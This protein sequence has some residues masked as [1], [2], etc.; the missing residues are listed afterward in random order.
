MDCYP[1]TSQFR[2]PHYHFTPSGPGVFAQS[3]LDPADPSHNVSSPIIEASIGP[4]DLDDYSDESDHDDVDHFSALLDNAPRGVKS[5]ETL[6]QCDIPLDQDGPPDFEPLRVQKRARNIHLPTDFW[7]RTF[8]AN[9]HQPICSCL[10]CSQ[11]KEHS[12][13]GEE[14]PQEASNENSSGSRRSE[15]S[16]PLRFFF[17]MWPFELFEDLATNT[18]LYEQYQ[19]GKSSNPRRPWKETNAAELCIWIGLIIYMGVFTRGGPTSELWSRSGEFPYHCISRFRSLNRFEQIKRY[20]HIGKQDT[21]KLPCEE[22]FEKLNPLASKLRENWKK[23]ITP[24]AF[25]SLDEMMIRF[26]GRSSHTYLIRNK[27]IPVGYKLH[28]LCDAG[29]CWTWIWDSPVL[30]APPPP[31]KADGMELSDTANQVLAL[32]LQLPWQ[33]QWQQFQIFMDN[34]YTSIR[35]LHILRKYGIAAT[36]TARS[37]QKDYP[38]AHKAINREKDKWWWGTQSSIVVK[39]IGESGS[40]RAARKILRPENES[41]LSTMWMDRT[42][43]RM[44]TTAYTGQ[45][46]ELVPRRK[47]RAKDAYTKWIIGRY[48][49]QTQQA[50]LLLPLLSV[51][52]NFHMGGVDI[53][54]Q[55]RSYLSTQLKTWRSWFPLFFWLIDQSIINAFILCNMEFKGSKDPNLTNHRQFRIRLAW[56]LVILGASMLE[57]EELLNFSRYGLGKYGNQNATLKKSSRI[58]GYVTDNYEFPQLRLLSSLPHRRSTMPAGKRRCCKFCLVLQRK[59]LTLKKPTFTPVE[60]VV[61]HNTPLCT[62]HFEAFHCP[63][64]SDLGREDGGSGS[65]GGL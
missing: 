51:H 53:A 7:S 3:G 16:T 24:S 55:Y 56:N 61:C 41:V 31:E 6:R 39:E 26:T 17:L 12:T 65:G 10:A 35:A 13:S 14:I 60:C 58:G 28:A 57:H 4:R 25:L 40:G 33:T 54:D 18:N 42:L 20:L 29:Y 9:L 62:A 21:Y 15:W 44:L 64:K 45:E 22:F 19:S 46:K 34:A 5:P 47:P 43:V 50:D 2:V 30:E 52:Y 38:S 27:P 48:W 23:A 37:N 11:R 63:I 36:G 59:G 32:A 8:P 1:G 49:S